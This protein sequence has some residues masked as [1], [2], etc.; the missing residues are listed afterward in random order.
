MSLV[1][2]FWKAFYFQ[3]LQVVYVHMD[4]SNE[5]CPP[6]LSRISSQM[7]QT[8]LFPQHRISILMQYVGQIAAVP[9][10]DLP[11]VGSNARKLFLNNNNGKGEVV[12]VL[13]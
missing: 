1:S 11:Y 5:V 8:A 3:N 4:Q 13:T 7:L 9:F 10:P 12:P 6:R 2:K